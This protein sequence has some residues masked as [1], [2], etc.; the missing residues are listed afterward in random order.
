M[1]VI[2]SGSC[3][4]ISRVKPMPRVLMCAPRHYAIRYEINPW[5]KMTNP[6]K[7]DAAAHQWD[8]LHGVLKKLGVDVTLIPQRQGSPDMVFTAN[9]GVAS[10][11]VFIPSHFRFPQRQAETAAFVRFFKKQ[12]YRIADVARGL[13]FEG[14]GDLLG[15]QDLLFGGFRYRSELRAHEKVADQLGRR[16]IGLEL[17]QPRFYH[18][19]TCFF[20]LDDRTALYFPGAFDDYGRKVIRRFIE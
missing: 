16:L 18:L 20:P 3:A 2:S 19:D 11:R 8:A 13:Y 7:L 9:A 17:T 10:G 4:R 5:M 14:E 15:Y 6:I 12:G 1:S